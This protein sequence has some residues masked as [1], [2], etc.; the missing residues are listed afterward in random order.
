MNGSNMVQQASVVKQ[1]ASGHC[2]LD[3]GLVNIYK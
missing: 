2:L 1:R 3:T